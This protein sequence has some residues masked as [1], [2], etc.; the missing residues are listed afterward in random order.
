M[1]MEKRG[2]T[3]TTLHYPDELTD[4]GEFRIIRENDDPVYYF[5]RCGDVQKLGL[6]IRFSDNSNM[7]TTAC[8]K[9]FW[10]CIMLAAGRIDNAHFK[11]HTGYKCHSVKFTNS[12]VRDYKR[13]IE[14]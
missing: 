8:L 13:F 11:T 14:I 1:K 5:Q 12:E 2:L 7:S 9:E 4:N 6:A 3:E 10:A